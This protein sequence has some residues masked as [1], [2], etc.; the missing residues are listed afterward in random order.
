MVDPMRGW[1]V[2][3][4]DGI[5]VRTVS[6]TRRSAIVNWLAIGPPRVILRDGVLDEQIEAIWRTLAPGFDAV[7]IE[8]VISELHG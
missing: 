4:R 7:V 5:V 8:V 1:A 3:D 2:R 6:D